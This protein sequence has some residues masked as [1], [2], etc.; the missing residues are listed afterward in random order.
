M[1]EV[2]RI[3]WQTV[4]SGEASVAELIDGAERYAAQCRAERREDRFIK[5]PKN[6]LRDGC[7]QDKPSS[8]VT[9]S[10][11]NGRSLAGPALE[12]VEL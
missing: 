12:G 11:M 7:W 4:T 6:W 5:D 1:K 3:F 9:V 8:A 2:E 10:R